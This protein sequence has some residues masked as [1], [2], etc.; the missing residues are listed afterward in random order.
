[1]NKPK[2]IKDKDNS[3]CGKFYEK[4]QDYRDE[5]ISIDKKGKIIQ[6]ANGLMELYELVDDAG[7]WDNDDYEEITE[8]EYN[9]LMCKINMDEIMKSKERITEELNNIKRLEQFVRKYF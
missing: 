2:Y 7:D 3:W 1:M 5:T 4:T 6:Y 8:E 9:T